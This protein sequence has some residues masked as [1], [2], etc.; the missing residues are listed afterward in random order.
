VLSG[1]KDWGGMAG[2][3]FA[4]PSVAS[5][6]ALAAKAC[7]VP[8]FDHLAARAAARNLGHASNPDGWNYSTPQPVPYGLLPPGDQKDGGGFP[9]FGPCRAS[10]PG[11]ET[12]SSVPGETAHETLP[13]GE[14]PN[15][16]PGERRLAVNTGP[17]GK[18]GYPIGARSMLAGARL[19]ATISWDACTRKSKVLDGTGTV[20]E[21]RSDFDLY[22]YNKSAGRYVFGSQSLDDNNEG[23]DVVVPEDGDYVVFLAWNH[24]PSKCFGDLDRVAHD[25][26]YLDPLR[27]WRDHPNV[28]R[29]GEQPP[30]RDQS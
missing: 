13:E 3:S 26:I 25:L 1:P 15:L 18:P 12:G 9:L 10:D 7:G 16:P 19:R 30:R 21:V 23:F 22:L 5:Q 17:A 29:T 27:P 8:H 11:R 6:L 14:V 2:T 24:E 20:A 28:P 4:S